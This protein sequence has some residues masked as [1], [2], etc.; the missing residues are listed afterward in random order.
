M[1]PLT[2]S[3]P[4]PRGCV[5]VSVVAQA[6]GIFVVPQRP[7]VP[8]DLR[9]VGIAMRIGPAPPGVNGGLREGVVGQARLPLSLFAA[10]LWCKGAAFPAG[11]FDG[12]PEP[13]A[14]HRCFGVRPEAPVLATASAP[15]PPT[16]VQPPTDPL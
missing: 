11:N 7:L 9:N 15:W 3:S 16:E 2:G 14:G 6:V 4:S 13:P 12:E 1:N 8:G 10:G 5:G